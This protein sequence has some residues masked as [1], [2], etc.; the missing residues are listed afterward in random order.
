MYA[1]RA[2]DR[3]WSVAIIRDDG[4]KSTQPFLVGSVIRNATIDA[5]EPT[6]IFLRRIN[7]QR[8]VLA[9]LE[10][11]ANLAAGGP[12]AAGAGPKVGTTWFRDGILQ[13]DDYR[14]EIRRRTLDTWVSDLRRLA[15]EGRVAPEPEGLRLQGIRE[16]GP[17]AA[18]GLQN[19]DVI[20]AIN[21]FE[22]DSPEHAIDAYLELRNASHVSIAI[23]RGKHRV[24]LDYDIR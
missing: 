2:T 15:T 7:G 14:Y 23:D 16:E 18:I 11:P 8:E 24:Q 20:R 10:P 9:L 6:Q 19:G 5:I 17:L 21:G 1:P 12:V 4:G 22:M 3:R 13:V